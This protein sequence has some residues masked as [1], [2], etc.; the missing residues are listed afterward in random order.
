M[1]RKDREELNAMSLDVYGNRN[2]WAK[3]V[4][5]GE[6]RSEASMTNSGQP[7]NVKRWYPITPEE[8]KKRM[9]KMLA[10]RALAKIEAQ[11]KPLELKGGPDGSE[12]QESKEIAQPAQ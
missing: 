9:E 6:Y 5:K 12:K 2:A 7:I 3:Q 8:A 4:R 11:K 10:D 1:T